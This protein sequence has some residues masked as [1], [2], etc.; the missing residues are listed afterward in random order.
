MLGPSVALPLDPCQLREPL[1][2]P[3]HPELRSGDAP[4][5]PLPLPLRTCVQVRERVLPVRHRRTPPQLRR[6]LLEQLD[7]PPS[8]YDPASAQRAS[9][10]SPRSRAGPSAPHHRHAHQ[11]LRTR[12]IQSGRSRVRRRA[13]LAHPPT[14]RLDAPQ[15]G[16]RVRRQPPLLP[17]RR[18]RGTFQPAEVSCAPAVQQPRPGVE[19]LGLPRRVGLSRTAAQSVDRPSHSAA[20]GRRNSADEAASAVQNVAAVPLFLLFVAIKKK[21]NKG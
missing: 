9:S 16:R 2:V 12:R 13:Q 11:P 15:P 5:H 10:F 8:A 1:A 21:N 19:D 18:P 6:P 17:D 3:S 14:E 4:R 7:T 20:D